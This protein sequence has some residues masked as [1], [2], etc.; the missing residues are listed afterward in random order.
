VTPG[1]EALIEAMRFEQARIYGRRQVEYKAPAKPV[2]VTAR[3]G[4]L[5][6]MGRSNS[7]IMAV[8]PVT[9]ETVRDARKVA[10]RTVAV[11]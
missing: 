1:Q 3:L 11:A 9:Y 10:M 2:D 5:V 8:L 4:E 7:E 6:Q